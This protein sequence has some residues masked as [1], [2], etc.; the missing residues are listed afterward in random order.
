MVPKKGTT[1]RLRSNVGNEDAGMH[2]VYGT[3]ATCLEIVDPEPGKH[4]GGV[5]LQFPDRIWSCNLP[6][7]ENLF[8]EA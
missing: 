8:E 6:E 7:F 5:V 2:L 4:E 3:E 1:Y